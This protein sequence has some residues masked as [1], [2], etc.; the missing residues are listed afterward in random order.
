MIS[1][2]TS[3][4]ELPVEI[5]QIAEIQY[6]TKKL[7]QFLTKII[8]LKNCPKSLPKKFSKKI[9]QNPY[10]NMPGGEPSSKDL[11]CWVRVGATRISRGRKETYFKVIVFLCFL[12]NYASNVRLNQ[13]V[14]TNYSC[15]RFC[16]PV[17]AHA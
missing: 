5:P 15:T 10:Q 3:P 2:S 9:A 4:S 6:S 17:K 12:Q 11:V 8:P 13:H 14:V 16:L 1:P 7:A